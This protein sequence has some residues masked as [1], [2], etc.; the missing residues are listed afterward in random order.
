MRLRASQACNAA[1]ARGRRAEMVE[2][3]ERAFEALVTEAQCAPHPNLL[4]RLSEAVAACDLEGN[5]PLAVRLRT[6]LIWH[7]NGCGQSPQAL[8]ALGWLLAQVDRD[9]QLE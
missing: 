5:I 4:A 1:A 2:Y 9:P 7:A 3:D 8:V 6:Q